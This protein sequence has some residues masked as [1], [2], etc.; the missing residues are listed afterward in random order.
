MLWCSMKKD[1]VIMPS[2]EDLAE[3]A[4]EGHQHQKNRGR[5]E[6][7]IGMVAM[8]F[9]FFLMSGFHDTAEVSENSWLAS[10]SFFVF[11]LG[12]SSLLSA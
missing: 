7:A 2:A 1:D 3:F 6:M 8:V 11:S 12:W 5:V 9:G 10:R 4:E